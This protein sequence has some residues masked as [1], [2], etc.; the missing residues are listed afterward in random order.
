MNDYTN[1]KK[2][3]FDCEGFYLYGLEQGPARIC[4]TNLYAE[5]VDFDAPE[6][7]FVS[8][9]LQD[10]EF[11]GSI[12]TIFQDPDYHSCTGQYILFKFDDIPNRV[13]LLYNAGGMVF[14]LAHTD[15][16]KDDGYDYKAILSSYGGLSKISASGQLDSSLWKLCEKVSKEKYNK[17]L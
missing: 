5:V 9:E 13:F 4:V 14:G 10:L 17:T 2:T 7:D 15:E 1:P 16:F 6:Y 12:L 3:K 8:D 11:D